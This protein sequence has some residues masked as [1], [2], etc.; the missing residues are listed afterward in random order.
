MKKIPFLFAFVALF[1]FS[2][3]AGTKEIKKTVLNP[4]TITTTRAAQEIKVYCDGVYK[5]SF[6]CNSC[7]TQQII[8]IASAYCN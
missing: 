2:S 1:A 6:T 3:F 8:N 7:T 5:G 4:K